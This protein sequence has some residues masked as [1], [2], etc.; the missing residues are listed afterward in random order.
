LG[1]TLSLQLPIALLALLL[2]KR[3][4]AEPTLQPT[5]NMTDKKS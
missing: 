1:A 5:E 4:Q 2:T 3:V